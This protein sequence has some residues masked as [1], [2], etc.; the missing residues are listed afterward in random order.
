MTRPVAGIDAGR[1]NLDMHLGG[2]D[3]TLPN[4]R[5]GFGAIAKWFRAEKAGRAVPQSLHDNGFE[6][7]AVYPRKCRD[8]ARASGRLAKTDQLNPRV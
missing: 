8:F 3:R 7:C 5:D 2:A 1:D 4:N 6:A